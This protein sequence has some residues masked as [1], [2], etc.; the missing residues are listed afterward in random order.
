MAIV[1]VPAFEWPTP[2]Y[3][4]IS[5]LSWST[6]TLDAAGES[7]ANILD[8]PETGTIRKIHA[9][10][11]NVTSSGDALGEVQTVGTD[12]NNSGTLVHASATATVTI[13]TTGTKTWDFGEGN[14]APVTQGDPIA[15]VI[16]NVTGNYTVLRPE[17]VGMDNNFPYAI[18][19]LGGVFAKAAGPGHIWC[20]YSDG[21]QFR[22][23]NI[24]S[25]P[26]TTAGLV[27]DL[28]DNADN[29]RRR[30]MRFQ[31]AAPMRVCGFWSL[32]NAEA[33]TSLECELYDSDGAS[34][35]LS[36]TWD[37]DQQRTNGTGNHQLL[38]RRFTSKTTLAK[39]TWYRMVIDPQSN[40]LRAAL[41]SLDFADALHI[42]SN[43][44][45]NLHYTTSNV[46]PPTADGDWANTLTRQPFM[47]LVIDGLDDG[48]GGSSGIS[49]RVVQTGNIGT[50]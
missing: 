1:T 17:D 15:L 33:G 46:N 14:G 41:Q 35:L 48:T 21:R 16:E 26:G 27:A 9:S 5:G 8:A 6:I 40:S 45:Q 19:F 12:G 28:W 30:G 34:V 11:N 3:R 13:S 23:P 29:P 47:G 2:W 20:E 24:A 4:L 22:V 44:G 10:I 39:D 49:N 18:T 31:V 36:K 25:G 42:D 37:T 38:L 43:F 7:Y 32:L 50:Y